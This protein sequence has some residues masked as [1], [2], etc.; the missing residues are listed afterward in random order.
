MNTA[1]GF[2]WIKLL[3]TP[4]FFIWPNLYITKRLSIHLVWGK[5]I[6]TC[7]KPFFYITAKH[8]IS[9]KTR[10][11]WMLHKFSKNKFF[12][13]KKV[14]SN[15]RKPFKCRKTNFC[16]HVP[17]LLLTSFYKHLALNELNKFMDL[18]LIA[19]ALKSLFHFRSLFSS[20]FA[21]N[22]SWNA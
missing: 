14:T 3:T 19:L 1:G 16:Y 5:F 21:S 22:Q 7:P 12:L 4:F 18:D 13:Y 11:L 17:Y 2:S 8:T 10:L 6:F 15:N 9:N 20:T